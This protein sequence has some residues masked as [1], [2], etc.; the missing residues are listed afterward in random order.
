MTDRADRATRAA[1]Y[2]RWFDRR[3]GSYAAGVERDALVR[4]IGPIGSRRILDAGCGTGRLAAALASAG[5]RV[6]GLDADEGM[7]AVARRRVRGPLVAGDV[8]RLPFRDGAFDLAVAVTVL[9]FV[10]DPDRAFAELVRVLR[11]GGRVVVGALNPR[12]PWGLVHR[13]RGSQWAGARLLP[14]GALAALARRHADDVA[15]VGAL[16]APGW[17]P[18]LGSLGP[19]L[20]RGGRRFPAWG[21]FTVLTARRR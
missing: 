11:P 3:W 19:A 8:T 18:R 16:Y 15:T 14:P 17:F 13:R 1:A 2:D 6:V 9:E 5:A 20:E 10:A 7:L 21:A 12:S 4:V